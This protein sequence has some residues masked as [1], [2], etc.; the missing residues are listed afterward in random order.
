MDETRILQSHL[1]VLCIHSAFQVHSVFWDRATSY[2]HLYII[3]QNIPEKTDPW[4]IPIDHVHSCVSAFHSDQ[5]SC[6]IFFFTWIPLLHKVYFLLNIPIMLWSHCW[7]CS[8]KCFF[9][10]CLVID[11]NVC[12]WQSWALPWWCPKA[13]TLVSI[14]N[15]KEI[16]KRY[17]CLT[18]LNFA[19]YIFPG[20]TQQTWK[21]KQSY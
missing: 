21:I 3:V 8:L 19:L 4:T 15:H 9:F 12:K 10:P 11:V 20:D 13:E 5:S 6:L 17:S 18:Q 1:V 14:R 7:I 16:I 2:P